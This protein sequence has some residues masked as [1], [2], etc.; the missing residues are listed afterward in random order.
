MAEEKHIERIEVSRRLRTA[1]TESE[2]TEAARDLAS[3]HHTLRAIEGQKK[4]AAQE[5][6]ALIAAE[7]Q[8]IDELSELIH[9]GHQE[10]AVICEEVKDF[11]EKK[12]RIIRMDTEEVIDEK[13][14]TEQQMEMGLD[15]NPDI[16]AA[17][18]QIDAACLKEA[19]E[20]MKATKRAS[21]AMLA[22]R[23]K[24]GNQLAHRVMEMLEKAGIVG[25]VRDPEP[26]EI[27]VDLD[28]LGET[29]VGEDDDGETEPEADIGTGNG[30]PE[31]PEG[32]KD[33]AESE[34]GCEGDG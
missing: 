21:T 4:Q 18:V 17:R 28:T 16:E 5:F 26:R 14:M 27:L 9:C 15:E 3:H 22:R 29:V 10:R 34:T 1:L 32:D 8:P 24:L 25:P 11:D 6:G 31:T 33:N 2:I 30:N 19:I 13:D 20:I 7:V 12:V 23:M